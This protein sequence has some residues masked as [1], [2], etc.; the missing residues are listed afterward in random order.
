MREGSDRMQSRPGLNPIGASLSV[1]AVIMSKR[2]RSRSLR[3]RFVP[4]FERDVSV[5]P[6]HARAE[7]ER[8]HPAANGVRHAHPIAATNTSMITTRKSRRDALLPARSEE[9]ARRETQCVKQSDVMHET[10]SQSFVL[11]MGQR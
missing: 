5:A 1:I 2:S 8:L 11:V 10:P 6:A 3:G 4:R 9:P 7:E